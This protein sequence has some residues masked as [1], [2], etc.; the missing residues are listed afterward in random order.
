MLSLEIFAGVNGPIILIYIFML[1]LL[2]LLPDWRSLIRHC[3]VICY[4]KARKA[5]QT[6]VTVCDSSC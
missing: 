2:T 5:H 1:A 6:S 3:D 4:F